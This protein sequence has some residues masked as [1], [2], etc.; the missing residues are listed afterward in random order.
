MLELE[1]KYHRLDETAAGDE[2]EEEDESAIELHETKKPDKKQKLSL[3]KTHSPPAAVNESSSTGFLLKILLPEKTITISSLTTGSTVMDLKEAI[4]AQIN[5]PPPQQRLIFCGKPLSPDNKLLSELK[6]TNNSIVHLFPKSNPSSSS[7]QQQQQQ[8][9]L[10]PLH[11]LPL[12]E[13]NLIDPPRLHLPIHFDP[14]VGQSVRE[15]KMWSYILVMISAMTLFS[16]LSYLGST[17]R[18]GNGVFDGILNIIETVHLSPS[19]PL[20]FPQL[21]SAHSPSLPVSRLVDL[22]SRRSL[23]RPIGIEIFC[24]S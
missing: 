22:Q 24:H 23:C 2:L 20:C 9:T 12:P 8:Q 18:P 13:F 6:I 11:P 1:R 5:L 4:K 3:V 10:N 7:A 15:V 17:G 19:F 14:E 21:S 16:N